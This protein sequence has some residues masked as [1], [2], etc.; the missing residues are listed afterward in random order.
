MGARPLDNSWVGWGLKDMDEVKRTRPPGLRDGNGTLPSLLGSGGKKGSTNCPGLPDT[1]KRELRGGDYFGGK[2]NGRQ[3][4]DLHRNP[5]SAFY[6]FIGGKL[7]LSRVRKLAKLVRRKREIRKITM[8]SLPVEG[9]EGG[10]EEGK[11]RGV[12]A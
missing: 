8:N 5:C 2:K 4:P 9:P 3:R 6:P 7:D 10:G 12:H 11:T 1:Q